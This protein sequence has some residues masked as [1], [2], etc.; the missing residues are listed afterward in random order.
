MADDAGRLRVTL[1]H[2]RF[3]D[4]KERAPRVRF[5][6]VHVAEQP[7]RG[8]RPTGPYRLAYSRWASA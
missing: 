4:L 2:N 1:H 7:L 5:G 6:A 8:A 3:S